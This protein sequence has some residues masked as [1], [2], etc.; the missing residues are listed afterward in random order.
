MKKSIILTGGGTAGHVMPNV[1]L[2]PDLLKNYE[3]IHYAGTKNGIEKDII[4]DLI[5]N[6]KEFN[7]RLFYHGVSSGKLRRSL[8]PSSI[9][10]N[11]AMPFYVIGGIFQSRKLIKKINPNV[12]FS[13]GGFAAVPIAIGAKLLK[14]PIIGHE[15]DATFG[16][17]NKIILKNA[18]K[19]LT[20]FNM[21][22][23]KK[24]NE[25]LHHIGTAIRKELFLG[26]KHNAIKQFGLDENKKT[27]LVIGGS[28]G[29]KNLNNAIFKLISNETNAAESN[30]SLSN[31]NVLHIVGRGKANPEIKAKNYHQIE[32]V[33]DIA[34][35]FAAAD[36]VI[37]RAGSNA[38]FEFL[39]LKKPMLL[40]PLG[41]AQS[42]GDQLINA[43]IFKKHNLA[44]VINDETLQLKNENGKLNLLSKIDELIKNEDKLKYNMDNCSFAKI[45]NDE[46]LNLLNEF[47]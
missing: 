8:S 10:K 45:A 16:L 27:L 36:F 33:L 42:R 28:L 38:I 40:V 46:I 24:Y 47:E 11:L 44:L 6:K 5:K 3:E 4:E 1:A 37:T 23:A 25:K 35:I 26:N 7:N 20:S 19:M 32:F 13:K 39:A 15:S 41:R 31:Y 17:A 43:D 18:A 12:I 9:I 14:V 21:E 29:A 2:L 22:T 30:N 34:D